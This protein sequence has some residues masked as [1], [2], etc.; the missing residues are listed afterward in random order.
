MTS[1]SSFF[2]HGLEL[3]LRPEV[4]GGEAMTSLRG[5]ICAHP[6]QGTGRGDGRGLECEGH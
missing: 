1:G 2:P 5:S 3:E 4:D 6:G